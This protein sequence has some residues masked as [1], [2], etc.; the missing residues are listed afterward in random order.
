MYTL[1]LLRLN[2]RSQ[3]HTTLAVSQYY[4]P[5]PARGSRYFFFFSSGCGSSLLWGKEGE[6]RLRRRQGAPTCN[7]AAPP[8][9]FTL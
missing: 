1:N 2:L 9:I 8:A 5:R 6:A 7:R 3:R 4:H